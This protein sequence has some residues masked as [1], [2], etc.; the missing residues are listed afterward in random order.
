M[1]ATDSLDST[2]QTL[3]VR[4]QKLEPQAWERFLHLYGPLVYGWCRHA[5]LNSA[6]AADVMQEIFT[7]VFTAIRKFRHDQPG[8]TLRGWLRVIGRNKL[9]DFFRRRADAP[10]AR[11]GIEAT[12]QLAQV[13]ELQD[14]EPSTH[15]GTAMGWCASPLAIWSAANS[16]ISTWQAFWLVTV[17]R[18]AGGRRRRSVVSDRRCRPSG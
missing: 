9:N 3:L 17:E 12:L 1:A 7:A 11:G 16:R 4:V 8:S 13:A 2:S 18:H 10:E 6:D 15:G 5:G 14:E